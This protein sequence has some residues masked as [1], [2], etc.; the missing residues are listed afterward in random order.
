MPS[1]DVIHLRALLTEKFP[2]LRM[3]WDEAAVVENKFWPTGLSQ[4]DQPLQGGLPKGAITE[5]V[6]S[7]NNQ[8]SST[9]IRALLQP[10]AKQIIA[11]IDGSDSLDVTQIQ[12]PTLSR[13][14]WI[15]CHTTDEALKAADLILRDGNLPLVLLDLQRNPEKELRKIPAT[16][17]YRFQR[18]VEETSATCILFAARSLAGSAQT[19]ITLYSHFSLDSL[20][21]DTDDLLCELKLDMA[22]TR[23][24][25]RTTFA[26]NLA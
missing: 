14:L 11:L 21:R 16:T 7:P 18:L 13:L 12:E 2:G 10:A 19:R 23:Q 20:E 6:C 9:L 1:A 8:G 17:W 24:P 22:D 15:R 26:Q 5:I 4:I 3:H 25:G